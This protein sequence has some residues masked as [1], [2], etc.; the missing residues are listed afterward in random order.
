MS[1]Y[2]SHVYMCKSVTVCVQMDGVG[3]VGGGVLVLGATNVPWELDPG[4]FTCMIVYLHMWICAFV[5]VFEY[6]LN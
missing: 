5:Y 4:R 1:S 6:Y 2:M 3:S